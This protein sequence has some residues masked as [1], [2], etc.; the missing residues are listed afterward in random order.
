MQRKTKHYSSFHKAAGICLGIFLTFCFM[1]EA[2][3]KQPDGRRVQV[4][5]VD[6]AADGVEPVPGR[7]PASAAVAL[8]ALRT[9]LCGLAL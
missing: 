9:A 2:N 8:G 1:N 6:A 5:G 3:A 7:V 4:L